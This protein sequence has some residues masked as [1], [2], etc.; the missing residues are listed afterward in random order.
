MHAIQGERVAGKARFNLREF[1]KFICVKQ[2]GKRTMKM[3]GLLGTFSY[4]CASDTLTHSQQ[5]YF[6]S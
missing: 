3:Y 2:E 1:V 4:I 6:V 5:R